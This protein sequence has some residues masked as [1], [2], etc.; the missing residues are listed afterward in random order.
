MSEVTLPRQHFDVRRLA[1]LQTLWTAEWHQPTFVFSEPSADSLEDLACRE[2]QANFA[3]WHEEDKAR[4]PSA[5]D[6]DIATIKRAIDSLNQQRNDRVEQIDVWL[7]ERLPQPARSTPLHSETPGMMLDRLSILALRM[8]HTR[9]ES[10]RSEAAPGHRERNADR[11]VILAEQRTD[12]I[13]AMEALLLAATAGERAFKLYRQMKM[14][15]DPE[16]NPQVYG[17]RRG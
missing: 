5:S 7:L 13:D 1:E 11:L 8:F 12:L 6:H 17:K 14:Y 3:L 2:H 10:E 16:L 15:N 4:N 9:E